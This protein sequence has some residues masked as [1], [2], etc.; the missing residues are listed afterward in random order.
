M[1]INFP[2]S[3]A[4]GDYFTDPTSENRYLAVKAGPP[5]EWVSAKSTGDAGF[6]GTGGEMFGLGA[7]WYGGSVYERCQH[8]FF[9]KTTTNT[10]T[11]RLGRGQGPLLASSQ[12][13]DG[14]LCVARVTAEGN[15]PTKYWLTTGGHI[16]TDTLNHSVVTYRSEPSSDH[17]CGSIRVDET[18][19]M[20]G[21]WGAYNSQGGLASSAQCY[22]VVFTSDGTSHELWKNG[23]SGGVLIGR[24]ATH[25]L[26][27][28]YGVISTFSAGN[29]NMPGSL[30]VDENDNLYLTTLD[31]GRTVIR[32]MNKTGGVIWG[33]KANTNSTDSTRYD[34]SQGGVD[35]DGNVY[36]VSPTA[37]TGGADITKFSS[38]GAVI[39]SYQV[40]ADG[41]LATIGMGVKPDGSCILVRKETSDTIRIDQILS[42]G[43]AGWAFAAK[44]VVQTSGDQASSSFYGVASAADG[45]ITTF[46]E[47]RLDTNF[48]A[49]AAFSVPDD[50]GASRRDDMIGGIAIYETRSSTSTS[51]TT[52]SWGSAPGFSGFSPSSQLPSGYTPV[53]QGANFV[54]RTS[55]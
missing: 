17:A 27:Y 34:S 38:S 25:S 43:T 44:A 7:V 53:T 36:A 35:Q 28:Q 41:C 37:F 30:I 51:S 31:G 55:W 47:F 6:D 12:T 42:N 10:H 18:G 46:G 16:K 2:A 1:S 50:G 14:S 49:G 13:C 39:A 3:P 48:Y 5:A 15:F 32:K 24:D 9:G 19:A 11:G 20:V 33:K 23:S 22:A 29:P 52:V 54:G 45:R 40:P 21:E 4:V 8:N 26:V